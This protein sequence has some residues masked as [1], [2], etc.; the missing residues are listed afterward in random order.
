MALATLYQRFRES[1]LIKGN[2]ILPPRL[3]GFVVDHKAR[4]VSTEEAEWVAEQ[5]RSQLKIPTTIVPLTWPSAT[6]PKAFETH[7]RTLRYQALGRAC[8]EN[9]I[10]S[11]MVAHHADDQA[12]TIMMRL[13]AMRHRSGLQG[14][15]KIYGIP[16]C[17]GIHGVYQSGGAVYKSLQQFGNHTNT[18]HNIPFEIEQGGVQ[19]LRPLLKFNKSRLIA[20]CK[21]HGTSWT[22]DQTNQDKSLTQRNTVRYIFQNHPLPQALSSSSLVQV[23]ERMQARVDA[24]KS[25]AEKLFTE[26]P[27]KLDIQTGSLVVRFPPYE[28]LLAKPILSTTDRAE[29]MDNAYCLLTRIAELINPVTRSS[30]SSSAG[31]V[32][33]IWPELGSAEEVSSS[34]STRQ[35]NFTALGVW[36]Q[37]L[38]SVPTL[39]GNVESGKY[40]LLSREPLTSKEL[41]NHSL[42]VAFPPLSPSEL[43][44]SR[45]RGSTSLQW[46][47]FD[48]RYWIQVRNNTNQEI[49][50][51]YMTRSEL[52]T[53]SAK[54]RRTARKLGERSS[55][56]HYYISAVLSLVKPNLL[57]R[58]L[59]ALFV[60]SS[61]GKDT[62]IG[63]PTLN[64]DIANK[65]PK[66]AHTLCDW[67]VRYKNIDL[68]ARS[69]SDVVVP[70][71]NK[72]VAFAA[73]ASKKSK[74]RADRELQREGAKVLKKH[75]EQRSKLVHERWR[76]EKKF[77][78]PRKIDG[79]RKDGGVQKFNDEPDTSTDQRPQN[80][81][82]PL[83][84]KRLVTDTNPLNIA[85][86]EHSSEVWDRMLWGK[87]GSGLKGGKK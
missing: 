19:V 65:Q 43:S 25:F 29:A 87:E 59:P 10:N 55:S 68:G 24:R 13:L 30:V 71:I 16:E 42:Q 67:Q 60:R 33:Q 40:W 83:I 4:A 18:A 86:A 85:D 48:N 58:G 26:L 57:L 81:R 54:G 15:R 84:R 36:W 7:A 52:E 51:R 1:Q 79:E 72:D 44:T 22:E 31:S 69:I 49:I 63:L 3:H 12:E 80:K 20:T 73:V 39:Y 32:S 46:H 47:F 78:E 21:Q 14:M 17:E 27:L 45:S 77:P 41:Q 8:R 76:K 6:D 61:D 62:L 70:G 56:K 38:E 66:S 11:L 82:R 23:A 74:K 64:L 2:T 9:H 34:N 5:L 28:S 37:P 50:L 75:L 35:K 53:I